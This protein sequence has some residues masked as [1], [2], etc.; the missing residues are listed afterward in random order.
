VSGGGLSTAYQPIVTLDGTRVVGFEGLSRFGDGTAPDVAFARAAAAGVGPDLEV[1]AIRRL[2]ADAAALP[3]RCW[4]SLNVSAAT[5]LRGVLHGELDG[6]DRPVVLEVTENEHVEDYATVRDALEA[7][8]GVGLAVDDA[9]AGYASLR[10]IFELRPD[11]IKLDRTWVTG[12]DGDEVRRALVHG[13]LGFA[14]AIDAQVVGEGVEREEEA[15]ALAA[16][17]V[18][19]AQGYLFGRPAPPP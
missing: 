11:Y 9:G 10:H 16:L 5:L 12:I 15:A 14:R 2:I 3:A 18:P 7:L 1:A 17:G 19:L 13:M 4:L 8:P 6:V